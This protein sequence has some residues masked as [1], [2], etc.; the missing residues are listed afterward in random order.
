M[1]YLNQLTVIVD[2]HV[3]VKTFNASTNAVLSHAKYA[4]EMSKLYLMETSGEPVLS[5][6]L[7]FNTKQTWLLVSFLSHVNKN[8]IHSFIQTSQVNVCWNNTFR[9][10]KIIWIYHG[11]RCL[12]N[13]LLCV[14]WDVKL[15]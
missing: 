11:I 1:L 6:A 2:V 8:I 15:Y 13:D 10:K 7:N 3:I 14:E 9:E 5:E 4:S 12:R